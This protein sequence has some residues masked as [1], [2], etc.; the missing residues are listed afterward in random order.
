MSMR[1][2]PDHDAKEKDLL[3]ASAPV[4]VQHAHASHLN[5]KNSKHVCLAK[6]FLG[7]DFRTSQRAPVGAPARRRNRHNIHQHIVDCSRSSFL[8]RVVLRCVLASAA[9]GLSGTC[10]CRANMCGL[11][12]GE[13]SETALAAAAAAKAAASRKK[14][15]LQRTRTK[16]QLTSSRKE[17]SNH[18]IPSP[19]WTDDHKLQRGGR[20]AERCVAASM[21]LHKI[22]LVC[23]RA[24]QCSFSASRAGSRYCRVDD[25]DDRGFR[26][27]KRQMAFL[28]GNA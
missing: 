14:T 2:F 22:M 23:T 16:Y 6:A 10:T 15:L 11:G 1:F 8:A 3:H 24:G 5:S 9:V 26:R 13:G 4:M 17:F 12:S 21:F 18:L 25:G 27:A 28:Y 19:I 7:G 20:G